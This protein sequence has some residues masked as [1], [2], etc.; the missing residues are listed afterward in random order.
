MFIQ[1]VKFVDQLNKQIKINFF[2][3]TEYI[4]TSLN[5]FEKD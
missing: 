4:T 5:I 1:Y 3:F 2:V